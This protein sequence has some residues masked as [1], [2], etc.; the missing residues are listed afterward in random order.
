MATRKPGRGS[1][2]FPL[3]L[4]EGMRDQIAVAAEQNG[5]SM[6]AE[7]ITRLEESFQDPLVLPPDVLARI[8]RRAADLRVPGRSLILNAIDKE[9][10]AGYRLG[11]FLEKWGVRAASAN[12]RM[13]R[14]GIIEMANEDFESQTA[15]LK[16]VEQDYDDGSEIQIHQITDEW[17]V[18]AILPAIDV[19]E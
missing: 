7:I 11:E 19:E 10:P 1:D 16:L 4:P 18:V 17:R 3:R 12:S 9:F 15:G 5:R 8:E 14:A 13:E 6:N 2:Q